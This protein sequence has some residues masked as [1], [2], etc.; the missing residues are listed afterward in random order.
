[1]IVMVQIKTKT[2]APKRSLAFPSSRRYLLKLLLWLNKDNVAHYTQT[3]F[4]LEFKF[5]ARIHPSKQLSYRPSEVQLKCYIFNIIIS[6]YPGDLSVTCRKEKSSSGS[7]INIHPSNLLAE[8]L[9]LAF[10]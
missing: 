4:E 6:S 5:L 8:R 1:M 9:S 10:I 7:L 2:F 3:T